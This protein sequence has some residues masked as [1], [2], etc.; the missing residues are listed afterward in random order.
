MQFVGSHLVD[1]LSTGTKNIKHQL[2]KNLTFIE[3]DQLEPNERVNVEKFSVIPISQQTSSK[4][5]GEKP[6]KRVK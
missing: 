4:R 2:N 1:D 6:S 5:S 3:C